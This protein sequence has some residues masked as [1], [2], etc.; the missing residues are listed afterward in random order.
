MQK[1]PTAFFIVS[2]FAL[3]LKVKRIADN[4]MVISE[5]VR[6]DLVHAAGMDFNPQQSKIYKSFFGNKISYSIF[7]GIGK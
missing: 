4:G 6:S 3:F 2:S 1:K 5:H 7:A